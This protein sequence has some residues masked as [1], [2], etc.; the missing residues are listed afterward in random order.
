MAYPASQAPEQFNLTLRRNL[1]VLDLACADGNGHAVFTQTLD[2][3]DDR[4]TDFGLDFRDR[5]ACGYA[6]REQAS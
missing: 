1:D 4:F 6:A 3:K 2:V 5:R